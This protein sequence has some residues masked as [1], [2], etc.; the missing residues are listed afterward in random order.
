MNDDQNWASVVNVLG[1]GYSGS[2]AVV[3]LLQEVEGYTAFPTE[4]NLIRAADGLIDLE[5]QLITSWSPIRSMHAITRFRQLAIKLNRPQREVLGD[6]CGYSVAFSDAFLDLSQAYIDSLIQIS[7]DTEVWHF[8]DYENSPGH[9]DAP[10]MKLYFSAPSQDFFLERTRE[11]LNKLM[12]VFL[13]RE[14]SQSVILDQGLEI[15]NLAHSSRYLPANRT[16]VVDRDPRDI[17]ADTQ[18]RKIRW[19]PHDNVDEF[20][21]YSRILRQR[22]VDHELSDGKTLR[23]RLEDLV[24]DYETTKDVIFSFLDIDP[25]RHQ[26]KKLTLFDPSHSVANI[27]LWKNSPDQDV[28]ARLADAGIEDVRASKR[29]VV[30]A[31]MCADIL[32]H[33]HLNIIRESAKLGRLTVGLL[34][35]EAIESYKTGP[36]M[37][38]DERKSVVQ[39]VRGVEDVIAQESLDYRPN[40]RRL[41]PDFVVHGDDWLIGVQQETRQQVLQVLSEWEGELVELPYTEGVSSTKFRSRLGS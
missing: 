16:I 27:G 32:H 33:G 5:Q 31:A 28:M 20:I 6:Y 34:T 4:F 37:S 29:P 15:A 26:E 25:S 18:Q 39:G 2:S 17:L 24:F 38:F 23:I 14:K 22:S 40:L 10:H 41:K 30:Y 8:G 35:D 19:I 1:Y 3:D 9:D 12:Q 21:L 7:R 36:V 13:S 11:Y